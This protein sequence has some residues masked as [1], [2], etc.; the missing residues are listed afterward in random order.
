MDAIQNNDHHVI[1]VPAFEEGRDIAFLCREN[2]FDDLARIV[3]SAYVVFGAAIVGT[4]QQI[5]AAFFRIFLYIVF[6]G[7]LSYELTEVVIGFVVSFLAEFNRPFDDG[8]PVLILK[9]F[10]SKNLG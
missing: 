8:Y 7:I 3:D 10:F 1:I 5:I 9:C 6:L 2:P 4:L